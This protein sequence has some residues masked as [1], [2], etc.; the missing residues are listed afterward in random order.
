MTD[1][2]VVYIA[3]ETESESEPNRSRAEIA[4]ALA[5]KKGGACGELAREQ[6]LRMLV[7][8]LEDGENR[9]G[10]VRYDRQT[11]PAGRDAYRAYISEALDVMGV[12]DPRDRARWMTGLMTAAAVEPADVAAVVRYTTRSIPPPRSVVAEVTCSTPVVVHVLRS[13]LFSTI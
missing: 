8:L 3:A 9:A 6:V 13:E 11:F 12:D 5:K 1:S 2:F 7:V 10:V 4:E